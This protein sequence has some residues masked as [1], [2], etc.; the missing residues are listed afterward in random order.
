ML[1]SRGVGGLLTTGPYLAVTHFCRASE[2]RL[3]FYVFEAFF[4]PQYFERCCS[5]FFSFA[6]F[7]MR[8][9]PST[10]S[11]PSPH[12]LSFLV[13]FLLRF[14]LPVVLS[15]MIMMCFGLVFFMFLYLG[16]VELPGFIGLFSSNLESFYPLFL[17][18]IFFIL[19]FFPLRILVIH[20]HCVGLLEVLQFIDVLFIY[21]FFLSVLHFG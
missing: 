16:L 4:F 5:T 17:Q 19:H 21:F 1:Y 20:C 8:S 6:L 11:L 15:N 13:W 14:S 7:L 10:F 3:F 18:I 2:L 9:L 12:N